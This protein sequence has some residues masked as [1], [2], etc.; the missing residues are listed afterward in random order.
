[1]T[2][3]GSR[4]AGDH[5]V[6]PLPE[7]VRAA[8]SRWCA[9]QV[10]AG[11]RDRR[12]I[13]YVV[14]EREVTIVDR[15]PPRYPELGRAWTSTPLALLRADDP[16]PGRW[17]LYLPARDGWRRDGPAADEPLALLRRLAP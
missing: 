1:M 10:P 12:Q 17:S 15:R 7:P 5:R 2:V 8:L 16:E 9:A 3:D 13:G 11:Q 14:R 6:M 4:P